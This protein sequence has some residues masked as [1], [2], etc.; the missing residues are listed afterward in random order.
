MYRKKTQTN[1]EQKSCSER[2]VEIDSLCSFKILNI[3]NIDFKTT[4][5]SKNKSF[6]IAYLFIHLMYKNIILK[7][8]TSKS[9]EFRLTQQK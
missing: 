9:S 3:I 6:H 8:C 4:L 7:I 5:F 1:F 2:V